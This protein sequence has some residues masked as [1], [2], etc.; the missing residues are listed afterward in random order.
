LIV[1]EPRPWKRPSAVSSSTVVRPTVTSDTSVVDPDGTV[2]SPRL[3][4]D[5]SAVAAS[6]IPGVDAARQAGGSI[7]HHPRLGIPARWFLS[8]GDLENP[9]NAGVDRRD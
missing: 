2:I 1:T 8:G 6:R 9:G 5:L 4:V 3:R 7:A